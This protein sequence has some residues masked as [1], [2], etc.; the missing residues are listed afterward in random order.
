MEDTFTLIC[1]SS[2]PDIP[3]IWEF[4]GSTF[5]VPPENVFV[6]GGNIT[7]SGA[8]RLNEGDYLCEVVEGRTIVASSAPANVN[9]IHRELT[10]KIATI[11]FCECIH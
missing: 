4:P 1:T 2:I 5:E 9:V 6:T 8:N 3:L 10:S 11:T 7:V